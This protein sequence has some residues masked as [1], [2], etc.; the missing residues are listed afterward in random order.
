MI[1]SENAKEVKLIVDPIAK[2]EPL[3][4]PAGSIEARKKQPISQMPKGLANKFSREEILD[5]LA[6]L[7]AKGDKR[8][9]L[10]KGG[11]KHKH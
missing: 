7:Y 2:P 8:H 9:K 11:H 5:L 10:Y 4:I 6:Y 3:V 1:L